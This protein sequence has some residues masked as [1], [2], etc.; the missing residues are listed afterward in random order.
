M[1][2]VAYLRQELGFTAKDWNE[3]TDSDKDDLKKWAEQET[4]LLNLWYV[5]K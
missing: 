4:Q 2:R 3:L 5:K 1:T